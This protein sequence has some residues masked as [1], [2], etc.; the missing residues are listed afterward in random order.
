MYY[1]LS[2]DG[3]L[4][5]EVDQEKVSIIK[6]P[7]PPSTVKGIRSFLEHAGF[8]VRFIRDFSKIS[9]PLCRLLEKDTKFNFDESCHNSFERSNPD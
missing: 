5:L 4:Q 6:K 2:R 7:M 3:A 1:T 9:R 8:Y